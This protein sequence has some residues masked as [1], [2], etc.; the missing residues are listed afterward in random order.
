MRKMMYVVENGVTG[1]WI[2]WFKTPSAA[3]E[4]VNKLETQNET[5]KGHHTVRPTKINQ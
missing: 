5:L 3:F 4:Y 2:D 1:E